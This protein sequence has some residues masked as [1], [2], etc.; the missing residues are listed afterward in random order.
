MTKYEYVEALKQR[1]IKEVRAIA[2]EDMDKDYAAE[3]EEYASTKLSS[4]QT[5]GEVLEGYRNMSYTAFD[6]M[7]ILVEVATGEKLTDSDMEQ[8]PEARDYDT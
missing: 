3:M 4:A 5:I 6:V 1:L 2:E 8:M 7:V